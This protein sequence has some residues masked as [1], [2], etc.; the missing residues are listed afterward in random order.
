MF[1]YQHHEN[2]ILLLNHFSADTNNT[3]Y[4]MDTM[5]TKDTMTHERYEQHKHHGHH[6][7]HYNINTFEHHAHN[8]LWSTWNQA[9]KTTVNS[10]MNYGY[11]CHVP[12]LCIGKNS[13]T[14]LHLLLYHYITYV[15]HLILY[16][17]RLAGTLLCINSKIIKC[18]TLT[19]FTSSNNILISLQFT[20]FIN[21]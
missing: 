8:G 5:N 13:L 2:F 14:I 11:M 3:I 17:I 19:L 6:G 16:Q 21:L 9:N 18:I 4:T 12:Q 1:L 20:L 7:H 15:I 10:Y